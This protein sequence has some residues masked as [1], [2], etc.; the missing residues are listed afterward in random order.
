MSQ[1]T[2]MRGA[3]Q[4]PQES[5]RRLRRLGLAMR[6]HKWRS[7]IAIVGVLAM[8][9]T[10][11]M[12]AAAAIWQAV[13]DRKAAMTTH[14]PYRGTVESLNS[15]QVPDWYAD[16]K[17]GIMVHWGLYSVPGFAPKG[18]FAQV[19]K[20]DYDNAMVSHPY[21]EDYENAMKDPTSP[22][23]RHHAEH[24]GAKP[25]E[26][27][28]EQ[29]DAGV[30][31]WNADEWAKTFHDAGARYVV[32]VAK[33]AD[34]YSLWPTDVTNP[35][36]A[37]WH[38]RRDLVGEL[39][40]AVRKLGMK[41]GVYYSGGVD[42]T[43]QR[44]IVRTLGDY[45][46]LPY[47]ADYAD[48]AMAQVRELI[49][50]YK[51][52]LLW[53]DILWPTGQK[54]LSA[55]MADYYNTVPDGVLND[56]WTTTGFWHRVMG[57]RPMSSAFDILMKQAIKYKPE[58]TTSNITQPSVPH[59]DF[60]TPEYTQYPTTQRKKWEM[61]RGIGN[62]FG[63]NREETDA[64][65][66][67][68]EQQLL[69]DFIRAVAKNG[70]LLLNVGPSGGEGVLVPEQ[71]SRLRGMGEWL[72]T[73]GEATFDTRPWR[74]AEATTTAGLPVTFTQKNGTLYV[75]VLG[76]PTGTRLVVK[77]L[78]LQGAA[79]MLADG[80]KVRIASE[81]KDTAFTFTK[82]LNGRFSP[83]IRVPEAAS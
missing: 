9:V 37:D 63:Y 83:I 77:N 26:D 73:A 2:E 52:D 6:R 32:M 17:L 68:L 31:K 75:T 7:G 12:F 21:A 24:Y 41:F 1:D 38:S 62:S 64:D 76:R 10:V 15:H 27:F 79:T 72:D 8:L 19:L 3:D 29:F 70:N 44:H 43:F 47:G 13:D 53:N 59:S 28:K 20:T 49:Q 54:R 33:Y 30:A 46:Y 74:Q 61:V 65:H 25:Y 71:L 67:S 56:R 11:C 60:T 45:A 23:G 48:Y 66:A 55:L 58:L 4:A 16:A 78:H 51:P 69:P 39:A 81:G 36:Q 14:G 50:R 42:W 57:L 34:G 80:S 82:P 18:T 40:A 22:T 35:H 5:G